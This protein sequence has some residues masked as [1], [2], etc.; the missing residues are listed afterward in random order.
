MTRK[1][2]IFILFVLAVSLNAQAGYVINDVECLSGEDCV[3]LHFKSDQIIPIPDIFYPQKDNYRFIVM[4]ISNID[5]GIQQKRLTFNSPI[6]ETVNIVEKKDHVDVEISLKEKVNYR[7]FTNRNGVYIEFPTVKN[8]S[9]SREKAEPVSASRNQPPLRKTGSIET[10]GPIHRNPD[11]SP[12]TL[13]G[14]SVI[15]GFKVVDRKPGQI[16]FQFQLS[17]KT[18]YRVIPIPETPVRLA[19]DLFNTRS[20]RIKESVNHL[21]VK[22]VRGA[23]NRPD[24]FRL[25]FDLKYLKNYRVNLGDNTLEVSFFDEEDARKEIHARVDQPSP[26]KETPKPEPAVT[27]PEIVKMDKKPQPIKN[28]EPVKDDPIHFQ[29]EENPEKKSTNEVT[30]IKSQTINP[31][32]KKDEFFGSEKSKVAGDD[33]NRNYLNAQEDDDQ[34]DDVP[35][36]KKTIS[37]GKRQYQGE[38][39]DFNFKDADLNNVLLFFAKIS[40]LNF[41]ID[42]NVS[43]KITASM[44]QVP[45]DQAL[46]YFLRV[47]KLDMV[48]EGNIIRIGKVDV[49]AKEAQERRQLREAREME[50]RLDVFTIPLSYAKVE[51][52]LPILQKYLSQRGEIVVDKR[53]NQLIIT[54]IPRNRPTIDKLI[55]TLD[56]PTRQVAIEARIVETNT[57]YTKNLGIQW[58]YNFIADSAYGNQTSLSFP[59]SIG[60]DGSSYSNPNAPGLSNPLGGYAIN[61]PAPT[62]NSGTVFSFG[63]VANTFQLDVALTAMQQDGKG[64]IISSPKATTQNN[65]EATIQQGRQIPVQTIQNN[66]VT[67]RYVPAALELKVTPQ[68]TAEGTIITKIFITN[69]SADFA[70]LVQGIP[71]IITQ[72]METTV[73]VKDGGTIVIGGLYRVE[74][75]KTVDSVPLLGRIP[76][77]GHLF[78][79]NQRVKKQTELL[80]F[81]TP[82][83]IK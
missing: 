51:E 80:I 19:I 46:E 3:Q 73:M 42:P 56:L 75:S 29:K 11:P 67:T 77:L 62:F 44:T 55:D 26:K 54:D 2:P 17:R 83:I 65:Q 45:W 58:G 32:A 21:N 66:T 4:R 27:S 30:E 35:I 25:V 16:R 1:F 34:I 70:N 40:G 49:L 7:V 31:V 71:P 41:L 74:D 9:D 14:K 63:N 36:I 5:F 59:N 69:N 23:Y 43:G 48:Q 72:K 33:F 22:T 20:S 50:G 24:V 52:V 28:I 12:D 64:E 76:L 82:R 6:I 57:N 61:L 8:I 60:I 37:E 79:N 47:N 38:P 68:I 39:M 53:T 15:R 81:I 10:S 78:R 13:S 18:H